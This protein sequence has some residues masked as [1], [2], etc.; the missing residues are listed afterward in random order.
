MHINF[1]FITIYILYRCAPSTDVR[2]THTNDLRA[3]VYKHMAIHHFRSIL[4]SVRAMLRSTILWVEVLTLCVFF[5]VTVTVTLVEHRIRRM[6]SVKTVRRRNIICQKCECL[7]RCKTVA[8]ASFSSSYFRS[9]CAC[10][11]LLSAHITKHSNGYRIFGCNFIGITCAL[12]GSYIC[13]A[14]MVLFARWQHVSI[15][16]TCLCCSI[17]R[18]YVEIICRCRRHRRRRQSRRR[19]FMR[20]K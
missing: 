11:C 9:S 7:H 15:R 10:V 13:G 8:A 17:F 1:P 18:F 20:I 16:I 19:Q 14:V 12:H 5:C 2:G 3:N 4:V 6:K